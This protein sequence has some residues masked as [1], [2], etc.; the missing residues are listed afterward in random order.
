MYELLVESLIYNS[1]VAILLLR[2]RL[3]ARN[4]RHETELARLLE[5]SAVGA[6]S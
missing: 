4:P 5:Y 1:Y 6:M 3:R 2:F